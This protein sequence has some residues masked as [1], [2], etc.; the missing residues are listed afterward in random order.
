VV[1][2]SLPVFNLTSEIDVNF[3]WNSQSRHQNRRTDNG[4]NIQQ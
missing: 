3:V 2:F 4:G 1:M